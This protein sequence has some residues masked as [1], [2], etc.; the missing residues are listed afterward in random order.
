MT[1]FNLN[2]AGMDEATNV[3]MSGTSAC[4]LTTYL[5]AETLRIRLPKTA[6]R[7]SWKI[8]VSSSTSRMSTV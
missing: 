5:H 1:G 2:Y 4:G 6:K 3:V 7:Q 8:L